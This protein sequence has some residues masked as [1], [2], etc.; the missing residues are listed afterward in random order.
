VTVA[1]NDVVD[2]YTFLESSDPCGGEVRRTTTGSDGAFSFAEVQDTGGEV[3]LDAGDRGSLSAVVVPSGRLDLGDLRLW[4]PTARSRT[5]GSLTEILVSSP[6]ERPPLA[7]VRCRTARAVLSACV[8][9]LLAGE[10]FTFGADPS[11]ALVGSYDRRIIGDG[12]HPLRLEASVQDEG[13]EVQEITWRSPPILVPGGGPSLTSGR[14]CIVGV[15]RPVTADPCLLTD[16]DLTR[17]VGGSQVVIQLARARRIGLLLVRP[18]AS[19]VDVTS[20]GRS[21]RPAP[22]R[23]TEE[24]TASPSF[25]TGPDPI[26]AIRISV[27]FGYE[28]LATEVLAWPPGDAASV[29]SSGD[30]L[31]NIR[32]AVAEGR[33]DERPSLQAFAAAL[34]LALVSGWTGWLLLSRR[35]QL[36][37]RDP[38][39]PD[40]SWRQEPI[41]TEVLIGGTGW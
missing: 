29:L 27:T 3:L 34:P 2:C 41:E 18:A 25:D 35:R 4:E 16:G 13:G 36:R 26:T 39:D 32:V 15:T 37:S 6:P 5:R 12:F 11:G 33:A 21:W 1:F 30:A 24:D 19:S 17:P 8:A 7:P 31:P 38:G 9:G 10:T 40:E 23:V 20:D 14:P 28:L 22:I